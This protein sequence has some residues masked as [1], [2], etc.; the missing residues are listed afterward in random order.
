M[1]LVVIEQ[2][3]KAQYPIKNFNPGK[4]YPEYAFG[5]TEINPDGNDAYELVRNSLAHMGLDVE[6]FGGSDWNPLG[7]YIKPGNFV[8]VKPNL[9][10][11]INEN[12]QAKEN[13]FECLI[14]NPSCIR[15]ICD[16]CIIALKGKGRL[17]VGDAPMQ[18]CDFNALLKKSKLPSVMDFYRAHGIEVELK[19]F[20]QYQSKF[21]GSKVIVDKQYNDTKGIIVQ[22][23]EKSQHFGSGSNQAYQVSDYDKAD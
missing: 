17:M 22:M 10:M 6:H 9:V 4:S 1:P 15:A 23:G 13:A 5:E 7:A 8:V 20:R 3:D 14:T 21:N 2:K 19:D 11:H 18:G 16:Y 12:R